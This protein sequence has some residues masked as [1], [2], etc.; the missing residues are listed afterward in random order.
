[1]SGDGGRTVVHDGGRRRRP[2]GQQSPAV[3]TATA[4]E[5][6]GAEIAAAVYA[7]RSSARLA[8]ARSLITPDGSWSLSPAQQRK[9]P[10]ASRLVPPSP[11]C[12]TITDAARPDVPVIA[13]CLHNITAVGNWITSHS[14][15]TPERPV[16][17]IAAGEQWPDGSLR[18]APEGVL[19]AGVLISDLHAQGAGPLSA[20]AAAARVYGE[21]T[22]DIPTPSRAASRAGN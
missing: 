6:A 14:Y 2:G 3:P 13:A 16:T 1:M 17:V 22:T 18:P 5:R 20:E 10:F 19:G 15:D 4:A 9:A 7:R 12:N 8:V 11:H 21:C